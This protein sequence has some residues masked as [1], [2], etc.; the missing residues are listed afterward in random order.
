[1]LRLAAWKKQRDTNAGGATQSQFDGTTTSGETLDR[2]GVTL[3][4]PASLHWVSQQRLQ[5]DLT[6]L[7]SS[8][9]EAT[10]SFP[11]PGNISR[12]EVTLCPS[13]GWYRGISLRF[14]FAVPLTYPYR[15]P[16]VRCLNPVWH[17]NLDEHGAVCLNIL[18]EDWKPVFT[19]SSVIHGLVLLLLEPSPEDALNAAAAEMMVVDPPAFAA[20]IRQ[21]VLERHHQ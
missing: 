4:A 13:E 7:E 16:Q 2:T 21:Q 1:M 14:A 12:F 20:R 8:V 11:D 6:E 18:R 9:P 19:L 3:A 15:P 5:Y 17:P 10:L